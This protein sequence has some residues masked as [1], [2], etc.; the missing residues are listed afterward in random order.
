[1]SNANYTVGYGKPTVAT[2]F[3]KGCSGNRN[4]R[5]KKQTDS[6][7]TL[8]E[9]ELSQ[10]V[11]TKDGQ[12]FTKGAAM[13]KNLMNKAA[14]GD[15][16]A[17]KE[18]VALWIKGEEKTDAEKF[19]VRLLAE[20]IID[21]AKIHAYAYYQDKFRPNIKILTKSE[22]DNVFSFFGVEAVD[23]VAHVRGLES[24]CSLM[25]NIVALMMPEFQW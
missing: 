22:A 9:Q 20:G 24:A 16:R 13:I 21:K 4:G 1:M 11:V 7:Y 10:E 14:T 3:Q 17:T 19:C 12:R 5:P 23:T 8:L 6:V 18:A 15:L 2:Q 25:A